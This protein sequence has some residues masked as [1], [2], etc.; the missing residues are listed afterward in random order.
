[1]HEDCNCAIC[2]ALKNG[3]TLE[4]ALGRN[5]EWEDERLKN[6]G[7]FIHAI[8]GDSEYPFD[9]NFHTHG[10]QQNYEHL[11]LQIICP[12]DHRMIAT[13]FT[14]LAGRIKDG[15]VFESG[16]IVDDVLGPIPFKLEKVSEDDREVLRIIFP[17]KEGNVESWSIQKPFNKQY[18][19]IIE[20]E[21][22]DDEENNKESHLDHEWI[23]YREKD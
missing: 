22:D 20:L 10:L 12:V 9:C 4:E 6:P 16:Q 15:E 7:W 1:M 3:L 18:F 5:K 13:V 17:D 23:P 2:L 19:D 11:D 8:Q 21:E 14:T